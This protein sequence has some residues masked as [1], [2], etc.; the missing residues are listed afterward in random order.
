MRNHLKNI[1]AQKI[2]II[3]HEVSDLVPHYFFQYFLCGVKTAD[4][5]EFGFATGCSFIDILHSFKEFCPLCRGKG[6][7]KYY[8][9]CVQ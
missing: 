5:S 1:N 4:W 2:T 7:K 6:R 9:I 3:F 8:N